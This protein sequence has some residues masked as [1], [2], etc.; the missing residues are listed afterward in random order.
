VFTRPD[1]L[2]EA[3]LAG[4]LRDGWGFTP[5]SLEYQAVG[6]GSHHWLA[7]DARGGRVFATVDDLTARLRTRQDTADAAF[8]RLSR[9]LATALSLRAE[10][11]LAFVVAP[12]PASG[13]QVAARLSGRYSLAAY[14][15][16]TGTPAGAG[17]EFARA[18]DRRA[19]LD[20][21]VQLHRAKAGRPRAE[22]FVVPRLDALGPMMAE[23]REAWQGG[24]YARR[25][26]EL[27]QAHAA[28]LSV[29]VTAYAGLAETAAQRR[30]R[31]V[32]TH[33][34]PHAGN[35]MTTPGGL[36]LVDWDTVL[37]APPERDLWDMA[38]DDGSLLGHYTRATGIQIDPEALAL[39]RL[40]STWPRSASTSPCSAPRTATPRMPLRH[41][42]TSGTS[43]VRPNGGLPCATPAAQ[44]TSQKPPPRPAARARAEP[45]RPAHGI[46]C[47]QHAEVTPE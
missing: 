23:P 8:G 39:Y 5:A 4:A 42:K 11:G 20:L 24:P 17:G 9:A 27:L 29:L 14:P 40:C 18:G 13:G 34:E 46:S 30:D 28:S 7:T 32:I 37:L 19:A 41:G 26:G 35:V 36:A 33:G 38:G 3:V 43:C 25:A 45:A 1:D 31:M 12:V 47:R 15:Y 22:D 2:P 44:H 16:L 21:L 6:F 10:A